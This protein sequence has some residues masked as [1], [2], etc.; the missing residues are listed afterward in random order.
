MA[1]GR[2]VMMMSSMTLTA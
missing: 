1:V 2:R